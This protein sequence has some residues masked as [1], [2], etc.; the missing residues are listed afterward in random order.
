MQSSVFGP[1]RSIIASTTSQSSLA[2]MAVKSRHFRLL[3]R[4]CEKHEWPLLRVAP[5]YPR[6]H[7]GEGV[8]VSQIQKSW[9]AVKRLER[10]AP[11]LAHIC[12]SIWE[13]IYAKQFAPRDTRGHLG[14]GGGLG[15]KHSKV[16][17]SCQTAGPIGT[18][19]WFTSADSSGN[20]HRLNPSRPS[21]PQG[22][23]GGGGV[24]VTHSNVWGC[25]QT[26]GSIGTTFGKNRRIRLGIDIG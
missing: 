21:M 17:G 14:G 7:F 5:Q 23:L 24:G 15:I 16:L 1:S 18:N 10:L 12:I 9:E 26:A 20:G 25:C 13:W 19:F 2:T 6:W 4:C 3:P 22:A 8:R 11:N